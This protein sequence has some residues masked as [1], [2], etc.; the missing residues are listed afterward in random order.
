VVKLGEA[1]KTPSKSHSHSDKFGM[2]VP[3]GELAAFFVFE[4]QE[5]FCLGERRK[6]EGDFE[7]HGRD[8]A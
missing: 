2:T 7:N 8:D 1:M 6:T 3:S 4:Q 5:Q